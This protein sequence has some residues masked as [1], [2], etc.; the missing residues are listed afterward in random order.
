M[1]PFRAACSTIGIRI[2]NDNW[3]QLYYPLVCI[4]LAGFGL[5]DCKWKR[6][7]DLALAIS[8]P[9]AL[10]SPLVQAGGFTWGPLGRALL[11][12]CAGAA[13]SFLILLAAALTSREGAGIGGGDIKLMTVMG[14]I[15]GPTGAAGILLIAAALAAVA[16]ML[17]RRKKGR[18]PLHLPFVPFLALGSLAVTTALILR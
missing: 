4:I 6:V 12:S 1:F 9:V 16:A 14:F 15:Y 7:P 3:G 2:V 10:L 5:Y 11:A 17:A 8:V 18:Q 13:G